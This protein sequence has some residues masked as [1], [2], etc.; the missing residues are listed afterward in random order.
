MADPKETNFAVSTMTSTFD[1][2]ALGELPEVPDFVQTMRR[3]AFEEYRALPIPSQ[4]TEEWRYTDLSDLD[5]SFTPHVAGH[6]GTGIPAVSSGERAAV[7]LQH[8][9]SVIMST[10]NQ[11]SSG[12]SSTNGPR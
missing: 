9:S 4:E 11:A 10:S 2:R 5:L 8:N 12:C 3:R 6:G 1:E 7:Q